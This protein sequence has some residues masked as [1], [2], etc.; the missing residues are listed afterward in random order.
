MS[1]LT[2]GAK[3]I[4]NK[5]YILEYVLLRLRR[6]GPRGD[7]VCN[8]E[9]NKQDKNSKSRFLLEELCDFVILLLLQAGSLQQITRQ[10]GAVSLEDDNKQNITK[11]QHSK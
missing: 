5:S 11:I 6:L 8:A 2:K 1:L 4:V 7:L 3:E 9:Q 10:I